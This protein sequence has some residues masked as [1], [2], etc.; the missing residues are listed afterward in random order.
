MHARRPPSSTRTSSA[1]MT[2]RALGT[3]WGKRAVPRC[4]FC[5]R[6]VVNSRTLTMSVNLNVRRSSLLC[7]TSRTNSPIALVVLSATYLFLVM[8][9]CRANASS[10]PSP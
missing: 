6:S 4:P 1:P 2:S 7:V 8:A 10:G 3:D 9:M 5:G